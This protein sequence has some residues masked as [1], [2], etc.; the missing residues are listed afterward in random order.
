MAL[1][2]L[3]LLWGRVMVRAGVMCSGH[4]PQS[5]RCIELGHTISLISVLFPRNVCIVQTDS[6]EMEVPKVHAP[7]QRAPRDQQLLEAYRRVGACAC[8]AI[9]VQT[10][11]RAPNVLWA[12]TRTLMAQSLALS[13]SSTQRLHWAALQ[14]QI[15]PARLG[16]QEPSADLLAK[17]VRPGSTRTCL[18]ILLVQIVP[19]APHLLLKASLGT[20]VYVSQGQRVRTEFAR[21]VEWGPT[22]TLRVRR[23]VLCAPR[24]PRTQL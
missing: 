21:S 12:S 7:A 8:P 13:V 11:P 4:I 18:A 17:H 20:R 9:Q 3:A 5:R 16:S 19:Q 6:T 23:L 24:I 2:Y 10:A 22:K 14:G 15:V 1:V